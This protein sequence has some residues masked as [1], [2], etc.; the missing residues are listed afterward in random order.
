MWGAYCM[1][2]CGPATITQYPLRRGRL[3][4]RTIRR[5]RGVVGHVV[6]TFDHAKPEAVRLFRPYLFFCLPGLCPTTTGDFDLGAKGLPN[7]NRKQVTR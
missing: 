7:M 1:L 3:R 6:S 5:E 4:N 2:L